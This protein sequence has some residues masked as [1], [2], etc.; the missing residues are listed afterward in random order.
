VTFQVGVARG[1]GCSSLILFCTPTASIPG[2]SIEDIAAPEI[3]L[4]LCF[5]YT[6]CR[7]LSVLTAAPGVAIVVGPL[8]ARLAG[9]GKL[10]MDR[11]EGA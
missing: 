3:W 7:R 2:A 9:P 10:A 5:A 11:E 4:Q 8:A 1:W 6:S